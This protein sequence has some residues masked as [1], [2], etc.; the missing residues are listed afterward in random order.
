MDIWGPVLTAMVTPF[1]P[2][3][4]VDTE[5]AGRLARHLVAH[6]SDGLVVCGTTGE[7]AVLS[8]AESLSLWHAVL[9][10][11]GDRAAVWAATGSSST[12]SARE[13]SRAAASAGVHGLLVVTP[14]YNRPPQ[15]GLY[16]HFAAVADA[17]D[18]PV[19]VYNVPSRTGGNIHP[20]TVLRLARDIPNVQGIKEAHPDFGQVS[21]LIRG[22]E[23][24]FRVFSGDDATT[25]PLVALGGDGVVSVASHV[26]GPDVQ[27]MIQALR[28]GDV[29]RAAGIHL[30][31]LPLVRALFV[32][33]NPIPVK[34]A[35]AMSGHP[36]GG[37]RLPLS[38][39]SEHDLAVV[40]VAMRQL[41]LLD[42][43]EE[44]AAAGCP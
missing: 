22:R 20:D 38:P 2:G 18:L 24:G 6:G 8:L 34:A 41:G 26:V 9:D 30:R 29:G 23:A 37:V 40:E 13:A 12:A 27:E 43:G 11:V 5:V 15:E 42:G 32:T 1:S 19:M 44:A 35:L 7:G 36:V 14:P 3:G 17:V 4:Q 39:P 33:T 16:A 10:A 21:D 28:R 31:L 25:F